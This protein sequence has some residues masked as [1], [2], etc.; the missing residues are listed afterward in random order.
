MPVSQNRKRRPVWDSALHLVAGPRS[1]D[2]RGAGRDLDRSRKLPEAEL[3]IRGARDREAVLHHI[4][5]EGRKSFLLT[6]NQMKI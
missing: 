6:T 1:A 2:D 3:R 4:E 5:A